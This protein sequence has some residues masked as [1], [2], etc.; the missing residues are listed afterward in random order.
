MLQE[1]KTVENK[2]FYM[3]EEIQ[4]FEITLSFLSQKY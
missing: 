3:A 2:Q 4:T 1:Y